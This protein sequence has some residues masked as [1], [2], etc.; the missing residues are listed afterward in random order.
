VSSGRPRLVRREHGAGADDQV[1]TAGELLDEIERSRDRQRELDDPE[2]AAHRRLHGGGG[3]VA[4]GA[5][6]DGRGPDLAQPLDESFRLHD[7]SILP[8]LRG[9]R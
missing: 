3:G 7:R 4:G 6:Q 2:A 1:R 8:A 9:P 5:S